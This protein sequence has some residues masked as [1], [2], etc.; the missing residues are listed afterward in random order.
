[1]GNEKQSRTETPGHGCRQCWVSGHY[2]LSLLS[3][4]NCSSCPPSP[5]LGRL[6]YSCTEKNRRL[7]EKQGGE[8]SRLPQPERLLGRRCCQVS[9]KGWILGRLRDT[10][11][12]SGDIGMRRGTRNWGATKRRGK[13]VGEGWLHGSGD[14]LREY[15]EW[16][17]PKPA[18]NGLWWK[19]WFIPPWAFLEVVIALRV[20]QDAVGGQSLPWSLST[21]PRWRTQVT[22]GWFQARR[23]QKPFQLSGTCCPCCSRVFSSHKP[24]RPSKRSSFLLLLCSSAVVYLSKVGRGYLYVFIAR[25]GLS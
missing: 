5:A 1:M 4:D 6:C 10:T 14:G 12:R 16:G 23:V 21:L 18:E 2:F 11:A 3:A 19:P 9:E 7:P 25:I 17:G 15:Y 8:N 24:H 22:A 13:E 20:A